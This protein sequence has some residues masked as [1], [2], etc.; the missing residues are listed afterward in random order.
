VGE[1]GIP[2]TTEY[3]VSS[4]TLHGGARTEAQQAGLA[5]YPDAE[6]TGKASVM[7]KQ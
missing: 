5:E 7:L 2:K 6:V 3:S 1:G 4:L